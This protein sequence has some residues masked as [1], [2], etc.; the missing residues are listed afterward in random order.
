[1]I[2]VVNAV[3]A[4]KGLSGISDED[5]FDIV[6]TVRTACAEIYGR[7]KDRENSDDLRVMNVCIYLSYYRILLHK[8][9]TG[10]LSERFKVGDI[11]ITQSP[12]LLLEK[13][14][15]MRDSALL[16]AAELLTDTDF[17]FVS[18]GSGKDSDN[19]ETG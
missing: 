4:V 15:E 19:S 1:M 13:A 5:A 16:S 10:E 12:S 7:L 9:L 11:N 14:A 18:V 6:P 8:M 2:D 17:I 3:R